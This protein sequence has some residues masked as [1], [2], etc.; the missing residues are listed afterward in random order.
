MCC[1][2]PPASRSGAGGGR[3]GCARSA[4]GRARSPLSALSGLGSGVRAVGRADLSRSGL[5]G[6]SSPA[7]SG[8]VEE[9]RCS[10]SS[11][12]LDGDDSFR[13]VLRLIREFH[14][15]E[16]PASVAFNR[17][18]TS[19]VP[20]YGLKS[21]SS[22]ALHLPLSPL[23]GSLLE[24]T[25]LA[26]AKFVEDQ[27]VHG[28]LSVPGRRHRRYYRTSSS[29]FPGPYT[30]PSGLA[31]ITLDKVSESKKRSVSFVSLSGLLF[32]DHVIQCLRGNVLAG[33]VAFHL[34]RFPGAST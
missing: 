1:L 26:L 21:E 4:S 9:N 18:K 20:I 10:I 3:S 5:R 14:G 25:N 17:C 15:M 16:E 8:V 32:G 31:S 27:T 12:D 23:L 30:V 2:L 7:P 11:V 22:P 19:L 24:G 6:F 13:S 34:W 29:S 33:L 28:F